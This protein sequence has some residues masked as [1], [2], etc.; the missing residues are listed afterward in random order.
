MA[1]TKNKKVNSPKKVKS[2]PFLKDFSIKNSIQVGVL[3]YLSALFISVV[4]FLTMELLIPDF[5][6]ISNLLKESSGDRLLFAYQ[7]GIVYGLSAFIS[8]FLYGTISWYEEKKF[9]KNLNS[10]K[11][12]FLDGIV[13]CLFFLLLD[14]ILGF[15]L[16]P[17]PL[18]STHSLTVSVKSISVNYFGGVIYA[19]MIAFVAMLPS[20]LFIL[21]KNK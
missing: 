16:I 20:T 15:L 2:I 18:D 21:K 8:L 1:K 5:T 7:M 19:I 17:F 12:A 10:A 4:I 11:N 14:F 3:V 9:L 13:F 6:S